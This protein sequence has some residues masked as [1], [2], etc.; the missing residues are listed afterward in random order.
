MAKVSSCLT[1]GCVIGAQNTQFSGAKLN[2]DASSLSV[3]GVGEAIFCASD[4]VSLELQQKI[5]G[6]STLIVLHN[7][8]DL[9]R[10]IRFWY[11]GSRGKFSKFILDSGF[12]PSGMVLESAQNKIF[13]M[14]WLTVGAFVIL[15][16]LI[17][18]SILMLA[19][20]GEF[21]SFFISASVFS[22]S[23]AAF[24]TISVILSSAVIRSI[25]YGTS[26]VPVKWLRGGQIISVIIV[27]VSL[28]ELALRRD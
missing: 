10:N 16:G 19:L 24:L 17:R 5:P 12:Q 23:L 2:A 9:P 21:E 1:G 14:P 27:V 15:S 4:V 22:A 25:T 6:F 11:L 7:R 8:T 20:D 28:V 26:N 18:E 13:P 3:S